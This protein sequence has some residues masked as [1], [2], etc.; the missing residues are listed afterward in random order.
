MNKL[1]L[2]AKIMIIVICQNKNRV[3]RDEIYEQTFMYI[4]WRTYENR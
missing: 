2:F 3:L 1:N 4:L